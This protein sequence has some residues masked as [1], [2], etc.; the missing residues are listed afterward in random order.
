MPEFWETLARLLTAV[1]LCG[2]IGLER[3]LHVVGRAA[4]LR[5][6]ALVGIGACLFMQISLA[7]GGD[8]H[9]PGRVAAQV[10]T[11]IGFLGGGTII[12]HRDSVHGL[13]TAASIWAASAVGLAAGLG[14]YAGAVLATA[15]VVGVLWGLR[16]LTHGPHALL[17][18]LAD[19]EGAAGPEDGEEAAN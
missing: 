11:G 2:V 7:V 14:W 4:G 17:P 13:T 8:A 18:S 16:G 12:R 3:Q 9:D 1:L 19:K 6:H 15:V 10:V 5:T